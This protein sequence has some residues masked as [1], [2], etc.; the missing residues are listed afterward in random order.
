MK[1]NSVSMF[2]LWFSF[3]LFIPLFLGCSEPKETPTKGYLKAYVDESLK[4]VMI[5]ERDKFVSL[6][7]NAVIDL[8]FITAREGI[9]KVLNNEAKF[10]VCSRELNN[11]EKEFISKKRPDTKVFKFCYDGVAVIVPSVSAVDRIKIP[12]LINLLTG[13]DFS[14]KI[15]LPQ[16]N[17]GV[18]EFITQKLLNG[19]EP[20]Y[21]NI[22]YNEKDV[23]DKILKVKNAMGF[24]G[25]DLIGSNTKIK[26]L[27]LGMNNANETT[28][29]SPSQGYFVNETYPLTRTTIILLNEV[30]LGL[31]SGFTTFLTSNE[32]QKIVADNKLGPATVPVKLIQLY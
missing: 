28:Y 9:A 25:I 1:R 14:Y 10:F 12:T 18:Y 11:E 2:C 22:V 21:V 19:N 6:Y 31:A 3:T 16:K 23:I 27:K 8:E 13:K 26:A 29:Y 30:G 7:N 15:Y 32:G 4:K 17:S 20:K 24:V 5:A